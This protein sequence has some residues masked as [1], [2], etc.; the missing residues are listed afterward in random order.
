MIST[1]SMAARGKTAPRVKPAAGHSAIFEAVHGRV[2]LPGP[3]SA[4]SK[5]LDENALVDLRHIAELGKTQVLTLVSLVWMIW[6]SIFRCGCAV[7][8]ACVTMV[9]CVRASSLPRVPRMSWGD[10]AVPCFHAK[11]MVKAAPASGF[12]RLTSHRMKAPSM[13]RT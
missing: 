8:S 13:T 3:S 2:D 10:I 5:F 9:V 7:C 1:S 11:P 12:S 6:R 4:I